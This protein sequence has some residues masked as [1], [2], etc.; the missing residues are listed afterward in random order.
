MFSV[1]FRATVEQY[2]EINKVMTEKR[3]VKPV[4][5]QEVNGFTTANYYVYK[6]DSFF[7]TRQLQ[8]FGIWFD[9]EGNK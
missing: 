4:A 8:K 9:L 5:S 6:T 2:K 7:L 1:T 3:K